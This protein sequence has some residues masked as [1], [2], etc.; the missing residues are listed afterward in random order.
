MTFRSVMSVALVLALVAL[1]ML[2]P[3]ALSAQ[4]QRQHPSSISNGSVINANDLSDEFDSLVNESNSQDTRVNTLETLNKGVRA[5]DPASPSP[6]NVWYNSTK[7]Q[8]LGRQATE[9]NVFSTLQD[10]PLLISGRPPEYASANTILL[11]SG[12]RAVDDTSTQL[13]SMISDTTLSLNSTGVNALDTGSEAAST[14]YYVWLIRNPSTNVVAGLLSASSTSPTLPS[15]YTQKRRLPVAIRNDGNSDIID[16]YVASGWPTRPEIYYNV[17][18][19]DY[20]NPGSN[21]VLYGGSATTFSDISLSNFV[22]PISR[23][24]L[25]KIEYYYTSTQGS[26][27]IREKGKTHEGFQYIEV[28]GSNLSAMMLRMPCDSSQ[29]IQYRGTASGLMNYIWVMGF[30]VTDV[31]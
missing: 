4:I 14:F 17:N 22:P 18:I 6:G 5:S 25:L 29:V 21:G 1:N 23:Q 13:M 3:L 30:V 2:N 11:K 19:G 7:S 12:L 24:A 9:T 10:N 27:R 15:G 16:F 28:P 20:I 26:L 8:F 31:I